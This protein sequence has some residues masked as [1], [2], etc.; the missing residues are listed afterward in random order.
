MHY[1]IQDQTAKICNMAS[2]HHVMWHILCRLKLYLITTGVKHRV[3][4][5]SI[6]NTKY[7]YSKFQNYIQYKKSLS[8]SHNEEIG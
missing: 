3:N 2:F 1:K 5:C 4:F 7:K 6:A 8:E